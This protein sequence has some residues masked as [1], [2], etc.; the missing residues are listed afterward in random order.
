MEPYVLPDE[1]A[2]QHARPSSTLKVRRSSY[3]LSQPPDEM[4][5]RRGVAVDPLPRPTSASNLECC[6]CYSR[7]YLYLLSC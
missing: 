4:P 5:D 7:P 6:S 1:E 2:G 3:R